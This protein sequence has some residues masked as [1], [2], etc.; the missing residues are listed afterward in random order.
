MAR[1]ARNRD[2]LAARR[3]SRDEPVHL[4]PH[5]LQRSEP[6]AVHAAS[7]RMQQSAEQGFSCRY[8]EGKIGIASHLRLEALLKEHV[9]FVQHK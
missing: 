5:V 2:D 1:E 8:E 4:P 7:R 3:K 6:K 9:N